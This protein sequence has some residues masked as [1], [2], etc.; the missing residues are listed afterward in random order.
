MI[1][2]AT[3]ILHPHGFALNEHEDIRVGAE[4]LVAGIRIGPLE[5]NFLTFTGAVNA[6]VSLWPIEMFEVVS[7]KIPSSWR[8]AMNE[9]GESTYLKVDPEPWMRH[10]FWD[11]YWEGGWNEAHVEFRAEVDRM[12]VEEGRAPFYA[13]GGD[14]RGSDSPT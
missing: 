14:D 9:V 11:E 8:V 1:V 7:D 10:D 12:L 6:E 2:R 5:R 3:R 13:A 4:Y